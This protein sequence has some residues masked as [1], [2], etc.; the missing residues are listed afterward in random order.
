MLL[1]QRMRCGSCAIVF[2]VSS[3]MAWRHFSI[4]VAV[5][6]RIHCYLSYLKVN[7]FSRYIHIKKCSRVECG[8][9][10]QYLC[11]LMG[12]KKEIWKIKN[13]RNVGTLHLIETEHDEMMMMMAVQVHISVKYSFLYSQ[14]FCYFWIYE[15]NKHNI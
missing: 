7:Y 2:A 9:A 10:Q 14:Y 11:V 15:K 1:L 3:V 4:I 12:K 5:I 8:K 6:E 13:V